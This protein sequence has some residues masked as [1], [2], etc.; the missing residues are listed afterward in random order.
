MGT[1]FLQLNVQD[2]GI[3][4]PFLSPADIWNT[5]PSSKLDVGDSRGAIVATVESSSVSA[6]SAGSTVS[7]GKFT[8]LCI[9]FADDFNHTLDDWKPNSN[10]SNLMNFC[11]VSEGSYEVC[12]Q[13]VKALKEENAK[14]LLNIQWQ[15]TGVDVHVDTNIGKHMTALGQTLTTLTGNFQKGNRFFAC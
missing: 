3:C 7:T 4:I 14:W 11:L 12:T 8:E 9:R 5:L 2:I 13:T 10:D 15:M 1:L 6:C